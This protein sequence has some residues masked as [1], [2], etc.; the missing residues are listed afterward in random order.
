MALDYDTWRTIYQVAVVSLATTMALRVILFSILRPR[1]ALE[2]ATILA[3]IG[4]LAWWSALAH[5][6]VLPG[7]IKAVI[8][9][10]IVIAATV[11]FAT[12]WIFT[13]F[14]WRDW[15]SCRG[16]GPERCQ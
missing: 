8:Y 4:Q 13:I 2:W 15:H 10:P 5:W 7:N 9:P 6:L 12:S 1:D 14:A 3:S 16:D 11:A